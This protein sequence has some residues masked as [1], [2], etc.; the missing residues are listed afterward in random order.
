MNFTEL[1]S[2]SFV[3][4]VIALFFFL[5][6]YKILYATGVFFGI[7][8]NVLNMYFIWLAVIIFLGILLP[9][10]KS[11]IFKKQTPKPDSTPDSQKPVLVAKV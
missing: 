8:P 2:N 3:K 1:L 9:P 5:F 4:L 11:R 7:D 6:I 10:E